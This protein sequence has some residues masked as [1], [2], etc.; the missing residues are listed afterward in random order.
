M[1][2]GRSVYWEGSQG[3]QLAEAA[4]EKKKRHICPT[5]LFEAGE[6]VLGASTCCSLANRG[7]EGCI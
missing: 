7:A 4:A 3:W 1:F 6:V 2:E 5:E